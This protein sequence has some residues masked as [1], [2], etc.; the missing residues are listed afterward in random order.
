MRMILVMTLAMLHAFGSSAARA[1]DDVKSF[2]LAPDEKTVAVITGRPYVL[3]LRSPESTR[4]L[5]LPDLDAIGFDPRTRLAWSADGRFLSLQAVVTSE[6][7]GA[8]IIDVER[9]KIVW[10]KPV[11]SV[12]WLEVGH[13]LLV[14]PDYEMTDTPTTPGLIRIDA[15]T[16]RED[17]VAEGHIFTGEIDVGRSTV[18][19]RDV[20]MVDGQEVDSIVRVDLEDRHQK[21]H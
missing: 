10:Q 20:R 5:P 21:S 15:A 9:L 16:G 12:A 2:A 19:G 13:V 17:R 1:A 18:V 6:A 3:E 4:T 14:V 11:T 7:N 8:M